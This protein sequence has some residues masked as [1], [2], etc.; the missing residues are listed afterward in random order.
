MRENNSKDR[1]WP[2]IRGHN[3][4]IMSSESFEYYLCTS[5]KLLCFPLCYFQA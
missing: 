1:G 5:D 3:Y 4:F 2:N